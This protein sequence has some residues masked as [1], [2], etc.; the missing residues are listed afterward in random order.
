MHRCHAKLGARKGQNSH[1][2]DEC[3]PPVGAM[4]KD[5]V[6]KTARKT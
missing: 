3:A 4:D 1:Q 6:T 5:D 2:A